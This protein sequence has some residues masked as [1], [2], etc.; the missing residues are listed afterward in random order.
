MAR[1]RVDDGA[2]TATD[3]LIN[4]L[5]VFV[6]LR[7]ARE[8]KVDLRSFVVPMVVV[9]YVAHLY[10]HSIP[11]AGNDLVLVSVLASVGLALGITGG[12]ATHVRLGDDGFALA[13]VGWIA[14]AL[15]IAG[16][17]A[18]MVFV[19]A[20]S[21]GFEPTIR[22]FSIAHQIGAAAWPMAL[23]SMALL[24]VTARL[25]TVQLRSRR[26]TGDGGSSIVCFS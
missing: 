1:P 20:V 15:L 21:N 3:Y 14:G 8:R 16:I 24:E 26:L 23:V 17:C 4:A 11:T 2:M 9:F 7:Q 25:V 13:R 18:R 5:F 22:S 10:V 6:V 12:F 19:L